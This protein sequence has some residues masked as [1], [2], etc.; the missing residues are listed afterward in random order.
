MLHKLGFCE[1]WISLVMNGAK[2]SERRRIS[3]HDGTKEERLSPY[4][5][6]ICAEGFSTLL[7]MANREDKIKGAKVG[8]SGMALTHLFFADDSILF[9]EATDRGDSSNERSY[10]EI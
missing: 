9:E 8:R 1:A 3:A 10:K 7:N 5:F 2:R 6:L 4:L